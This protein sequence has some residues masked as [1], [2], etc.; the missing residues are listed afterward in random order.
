MISENERKVYNALDQLGIPYKRYEHIPVHTIQDIVELN[1]EMQGVH[2]KNLFV[3][4]HNGKEHY[5]ILVDQEK[6]VDLKRLAKE[7]GSTRLSF[8]SSERLMKHLG[9]TPG[10][11][12]PF[13]LLND[14]ER[15][16]TVIIDEDLKNSEYI[17]F[18]PNVNTASISVPYEGLINF[19]RWR[20]NE[21]RFVKI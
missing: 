14:E 5:L 7:I 18:H 13:G 11:V 3:R 6:I 8:A 9:L 19:L 20:G 12:T 4:N 16:V 2:C 15:K 1:M 21:Y 17:C 10:A